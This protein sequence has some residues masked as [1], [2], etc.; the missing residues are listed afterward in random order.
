MHTSVLL[1]YFYHVF[2]IL[3]CVYVSY[4]NPLPD[5]NSLSDNFISSCPYAFRS[6][7]MNSRIMVSGLIEKYLVILI[8]FLSHSLR[9]SSALVS[10]STP[11]LLLNHVPASS[12]IFSSPGSEYFILSML[13]QGTTEPRHISIYFALLFSHPGI[14]TKLLPVYNT[15]SKSKSTY[16]QHQL[17]PKDDLHWLVDIQKWHQWVVNYDSL[18]TEYTRLNAVATSSPNVKAL[19]P[20]SHWQAASTVKTGIYSG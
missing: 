4:W 12:V 19:F 7:S 20:N 1:N 9:A 2:V 3:P 11:I 15:W 18:C 10:L 5:Q 16:D 6:R 8:V 14:R 17:V 13:H